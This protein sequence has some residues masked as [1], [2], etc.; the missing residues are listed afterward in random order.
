MEWLMV[1]LWLAWSCW[2]YARSAAAANAALWRALAELH[3]S[4]SIQ[5]GITDAE[6]L[7]VNDRIDELEAEGI[8]IAPTQ[9]CNCANCRKRRQLAVN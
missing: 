1:T 9:R 8:T 2:R 6:L 7:A 5:L 3:S 4:T